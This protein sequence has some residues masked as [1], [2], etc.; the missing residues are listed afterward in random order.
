MLSTPELEVKD[1]EETVGA[2][3]SRV[4]E[5]VETND[6]FPAASVVYNL[7]VPST[8]PAALMFVSV[9]AVVIAAEFHEVSAAPVMFARFATVML[10]RTR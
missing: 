9:S 6:K 10:L 4:A 2:V 5:L 1:K 7:Y 8:K 3:V